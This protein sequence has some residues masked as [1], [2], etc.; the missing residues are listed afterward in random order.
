MNEQAYKLLIEVENSFFVSHHAF[1]R[2]DRLGL[3]IL[4]DAMGYVR[5]P[6]HFD[7]IRAGMERPTKTFWELWA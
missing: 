2:E 7:T 4:H 3:Q 6:A 1:S 5:N